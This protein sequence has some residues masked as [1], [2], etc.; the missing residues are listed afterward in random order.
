MTET[1]TRVQLVAEI[2]RG[3][4]G[5]WFVHMTG[6]GY[7]QER[8]LTDP[9][10]AMRVLDGLVEDG[11]HIEDPLHYCE[12]YGIWPDEPLSQYEDSRD[13]AEQPGAYAGGVRGDDGRGQADEEP[14]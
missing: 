10:Q 6:N 11:W 14:L 4:Y 1:L 3:P 9:A 8:A 7:V 13:A 5:L 2:R 12:L